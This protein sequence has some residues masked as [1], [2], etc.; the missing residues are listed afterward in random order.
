L[1]YQNASDIR[2]DLKRLKR[3][4]ESSRSAVPVATEDQD[5][6]EAAVEVPVSRRPSI[7]KQKRLSSSAQPVV[8]E[9][10]PRH[11]WKG[12]VP[13]AGVALAVLIAGGLYYH[14]RPA[15]ALTEKDTIVLADFDNKTGDTVFDDTLKQALAVDL[16]QSPFLNVL[17]DRRVGETLRLM[18]RPPNDRITREVAQEICLRNRQQ[19]ATGRVDFAPGQRVH[20]RPGG[21]GM[22]QRR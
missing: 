6:A 19:G 5:D 1:R 12:L 10:S 8:M 9:Q 18:G 3:E 7:G 16:E 22:R 4:T 11:Q 14:S 13:V 21:R 20:G 2:T 17:S 15:K